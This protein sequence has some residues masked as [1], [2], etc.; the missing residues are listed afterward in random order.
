MAKFIIN[1]GF[2]LR[3]AVRLGGAKNASS[4]LMIASLLAK[5]ETRL[6]NLARIGD[7][8]ITKK[9]IESLGGKVSCHGERT[10]FID[11]T[12]IKNFQVS[13]EFA[14]ESRMSTMFVSPLLS[15]FGQAILPLPGG[16][17]IG[18]RPLERHFGGLEKLG[19]KIEFTNGCFRVSC[20][21]LRGAHYCFDKNTHTGTETLIMAA[22][23]AEGRTILENAA[24]EP[25]VDD[26][27]KFLSKMGAKIR[28]SN[29]TI[30]ID[31]VLQLHPAIHSVMPDRNEAVTY[32]CAALGTKGDIIIENA[33]KEHLGAFL[34]KFREI[35]AGFEIADHGIRFF[36]KGDLV[37]TK[38]ITKPYPGFM[39]DWQPVWTA[40]MT[41]AVGES[42]VIETIFPSRFVY[43]N[44]LIR[45]GAKIRFFNPKVRNPEK[46]YN[47]NLENDNPQN[48]HGLKIKGPQ[49]LSG[50]KVKIPDLRAGATLVLAAL[51]AKGESLLTNVY[52]V[53][54]GYEN[55][56]MHL[57]ELGAE[58]K[59][60]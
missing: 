57:M 33:R 48:F 52:Q 47:F 60:V 53:D 51:I 2:P 38:V 45:M 17:K 6:L 24:Q 25:E 7:V 10:S 19:A 49:I 28:R 42:T 40:L 59:R 54:R 11:A 43:V 4:K 34:E 9:M 50:I 35:N 44:Y 39:T 27:I 21:K 58:I 55:L 12:G 41:Q 15:R 30:T 8:A 20:R 14:K 3:G 26:L 56:D 29:R 32:A 36:Y 31:G 23:C 22:V 37:A 1:G 16:D 5:G 13:E 18:L 46:F